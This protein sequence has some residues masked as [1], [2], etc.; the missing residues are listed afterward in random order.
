MTKQHHASNYQPLAG[1]DDGHQK[2][3]KGELAQLHSWLRS[4][5]HRGCTKYQECD[6]EYAGNS[7]EVPTPN[8]PK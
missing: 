8:E 7:D 6:E 2:K 5:I 4:G 3:A 1:S